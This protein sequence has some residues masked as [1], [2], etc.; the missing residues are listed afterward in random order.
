MRDFAQTLLTVVL[1]ARMEVDWKKRSLLYEEYLVLKHGVTIE[2]F[3]K[4]L[5]ETHPEEVR[6]RS[7]KRT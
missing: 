1:E 2:F 3:D 5:K 7:I 4:W 6:T